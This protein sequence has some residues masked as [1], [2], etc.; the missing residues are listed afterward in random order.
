MAG[1][2]LNIL[3]LGTLSWL[4]EK[5]HQKKLRE[6]DHVEIKAHTWMG[7]SGKTRY[8]RRYLGPIQI[9]TFLSTS[10]RMNSKVDDY[11]MILN[12]L[13]YDSDNSENKNDYFLQLMELNKKIIKYI[14]Q[15][16]RRETLRC[17]T[18]WKNNH[19]ESFLAYQEARKKA[20]RLDSKL[21]DVKNKLNQTQ[22]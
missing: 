7:I 5:S 13:L 9:K 16:D 4:F 19:T 1:G 21:E 3:F 10:N 8:N 20:I 2:C 17:Y 22:T 11:E 18:E 15:I 14:K 12:K 6:A